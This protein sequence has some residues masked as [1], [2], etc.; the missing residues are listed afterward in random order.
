MEFVDLK[1]Q[2]LAYKEEIDSEI[3][4]VLDNAAFINGPQVSDLEHELKEFIGTGD[5]IVYSS[6]T[7]ALLLPMMA[8]KVKSG[9]E[10]LV[11]AFTFIATATMVKHLGAKP[12]FVDVDPVT[13]TIDPGDA[14]K[15]ITNRTVGII[16]VSLYGQCADMGQLNKIAVEHGL[17]VM[18]DAAQSFGATQEGVPSCALS[19][20]AT[21]S[22]FPAKPLGGYGDGG[23]VFTQDEN[24]AHE[25]RSIRNHGQDGRYNHVR[26]GVNARMGTLQAAILRVKLR[27]Y[28]EELKQR[29]LIA[30]R[31]S[32]ELKTCVTVPV[33]AEE[34]TSSWAQYTIVCEKRDKLREWLTVRGIPTSVHYPK[35]LH[36]QPVFDYVSPIPLPVSEMLS[37]HVVSLPMHPFLSENEILSVCRAIKD[38]YGR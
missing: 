2:Y 15:K 31:Y 20:I 29:D 21:T 6:G 32:D 9:D 38:F 25:L 11:P 35:P 3:Q 12:V 10:V 34:N 16:P 14:A 22:F 13:F 30:D 4:L 28:S 23:A 37:E 5:A 8:F 33:I 19:E 1:R 17:W 27:H 7:D 26:L 36:Q 18:E 24:L